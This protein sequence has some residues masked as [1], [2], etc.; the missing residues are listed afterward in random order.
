LSGPYARLTGLDG[1]VVYRT[2]GDFDGNGTVDARD[3]KVWRASTG[4]T[5]DADAGFDGDSDGQDFLIWQQRLAPR[6]QLLFKTP[7]PSRKHGC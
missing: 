1:N 3:L 7:Y 2:P 5:P 6:R 4:I